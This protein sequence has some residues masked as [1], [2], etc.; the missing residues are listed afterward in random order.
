MSDDKIVSS[1]I[2]K[3]KIVARTQ[4]IELTKKLE[5]IL[6]KPLDISK[7]QQVSY[8]NGVGIAF[9]CSKTGESFGVLLE[10]SDKYRITQIDKAGEGT[11]DFKPFALEAEDVDFSGFYCPCCGFDSSKGI[12][13]FIRCGKCGELICGSSTRKV[14][15]G[16]EFKCF[17]GNFGMVSSDLINSYTATQGDST[18]KLTGQS[19]FLLK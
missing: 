9:K 18:N 1:Q 10:K 16:T 13:S 11:S 4:R 2:G 15:F 7:P 14:E 12:Y 8:G 17:C 3:G 5:A 6:G 19:K